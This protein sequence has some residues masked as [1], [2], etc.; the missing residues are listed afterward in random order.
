MGAGHFSLLAGET[1][2]EDGPT[3][4][5]PATPKKFAHCVDA[6]TTDFTPEKSLRITSKNTFI[7]VIG[8]EKRFDKRSLRR[9]T[10]EPDRPPVEPPDGRRPGLEAGPGDAT[11][12]LAAEVLQEPP[13]CD[14]PS[15]GARIQVSTPEEKF[16][17]PAFQ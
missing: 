15:Q 4:S 5:G 12:A 2:A 16:T 1:D 11:D 9:W 14:P 3:G 7:E 10:S 6:A 13:P 17:K 8:D